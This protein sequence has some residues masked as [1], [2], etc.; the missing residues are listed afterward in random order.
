MSTEIIVAILCGSTVGALITQIGNYIS[1][2]KNHSE[3]KEDAESEEIKALR[4]ALKLLMLDRI[5]ELGQ[6]YIADGEVD[7][8]DLR[9][10]RMMH[11]AY[12]NL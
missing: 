12:H 11:S 4:E 10:L 2:R 3:L 5:R 7:F 1:A 8:D 6:T 9:I